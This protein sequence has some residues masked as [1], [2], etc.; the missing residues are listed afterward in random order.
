MNSQRMA[1][2]SAILDALFDW[3]APS[4]KSQIRQRDTDHVRRLSTWASI[5]GHT[6]IP[7]FYCMTRFAAPHS[8]SNLRRGA[9]CR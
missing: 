7:V 3:F 4:R 1:P 2:H 5:D 9:F 8:L 6:D